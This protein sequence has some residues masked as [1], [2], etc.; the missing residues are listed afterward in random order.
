MQIIAKKRHERSPRRRYI[1]IQADR[2]IN[3]PEPHRGPL[4]PSLGDKSVY[5][6]YTFYPKSIFAEYDGWAFCRWYLGQLSRLYHWGVPV[7]SPRREKRS[8]NAASVMSANCAAPKPDN[9][10][11]VRVSAGI[12]GGIVDKDQC[13]MIL[14]PRYIEVFIWCH[15]VFQLFNKIN[16]SKSKL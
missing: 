9:V 2:H 14:H 1:E 11:W 8:R 15:V 13:N 7:L 4:V 10:P 6:S 16:L 3:S 5:H 12:F